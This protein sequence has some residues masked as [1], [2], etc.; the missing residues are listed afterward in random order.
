MQEM[1]DKVGIVGGM[2]CDMAVTMKTFKT[3]KEWLKART[4]MIGGSDAAAVIGQN[5][6][7]SNTEL[8]RIKAGLEKQKDIS[9]KEVVKYG[10]E[11]ENYLRELF[12]LDFP[13][14]KVMYKE[15]NIWLNDKYPFAHASLDGWL[16]DE[17][18]RKGILE[19]KTTNIVRSEQKEKWNNQIPQNYYAQVLHYFMVTEF[20]FAVLKA[21]LKFQ[22][23]NDVMLN[24]KHFFIER[25]DVEEDIEYL[26]KEEEKFA[27]S[28]QKGR[29][30]SLLLPDI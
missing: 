11:A 18:G 8:W 25:K 7:M 16:E 5:P 28:V 4:S 30:P 1:S 13:K 26:Y 29:M 19:I 9:D 3:K 23:D 15:N 14:Y 12:K 27:A 6:W 17:D 20:D 10:T 21:Q 2:K 24:V 22:F